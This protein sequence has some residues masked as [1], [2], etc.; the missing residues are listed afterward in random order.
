MGDFKEQHDCFV[1]AV[2]AVRAVAPDARAH[3]SNS[4]AILRAPHMHHD[5]VRPGLALFGY[6]A[7]TASGVVDLRPAMTMLAPVTQVKTVAPGTPVGY[8]RTW[9]ASEPALV[10]TYFRSSGCDAG[11]NRSK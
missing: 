4:G 9:T 11:Y 7:E 2:D 3:C 10:R 5:L 6:A 1:A 8:G